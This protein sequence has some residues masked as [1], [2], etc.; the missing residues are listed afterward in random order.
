VATLVRW[1]PF[2]EVAALHNELSRFMNAIEGN[3]R[4]TQSWVPALD[5]WETDDALVYAFDLPGVEEDKI[6]VEVEDSMLTVSAERERTEE[7]SG[8]RFH[9]FERR[10]GAFSR[11]V[12][13]PQGI[14]EDQIKASYTGG[15]L[16]IRVPKPAQVKPRRI[17]IGGDEEQATIEG[18]A[19]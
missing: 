8:D 18:S 5:V 3:G 16:E 11:S 14:D 15:V 19:S 13:L 9:R 2:R 10:H 12:G 1:D 6:S 7:V 17:A 4:T